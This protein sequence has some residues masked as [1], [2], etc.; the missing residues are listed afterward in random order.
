MTRAEGEKKAIEL[1]AEANRNKAVQE[2]EASQVAA[3][4]EA[5]GRKAV[6]AAKQTELEAE[7][8]G[9]QAKLE[10][11][12]AGIQ[13]KLEAEA[14]GVQKKAEAYR[15]LNQSG[16]LLIILEHLPEVLNALGNAVHN[17]G[18]GTVAPI[19][20]AIGTGLSGIEEVRIFDLGGGNS[21]TG[22]DALSRFMDIVPKETFTL[23]QQVH[24]LGLN[25]VVSQLATKF[26]LD[27]TSILGA[28]ATAGDDDGSSTKLTPVAAVTAEPEGGDDEPNSNPNQ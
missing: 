22:K 28:V 24:G 5:E 19:A 13:A 17:A 14:K 11:E 16:Q 10:A 27:L 23:L 25:D 2:A 7:A 18:L 21:S 20:Q 4:R 6:A 12:A 3:Q 1:L 15:Q 26:G 9:N 8:A